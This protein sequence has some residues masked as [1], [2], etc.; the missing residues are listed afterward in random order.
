MTIVT[1][2][3]I[4]LFFLCF[5]SFLNS[6]A[7]RLVHPKHPRTKR[8]SCPHCHT[9]IAFYDLIPVV[10]W[11][12]LRARCRWCNKSISILYPLIELITAVVFVCL[13]I[14][15]PWTLWLPYGLFFTALIISIRTDLET[16]LLSRMVTIWFI[17]LGLFFSAVKLL[18]IT[19]S[20]SL[21]GAI[22][23]YALLWSVSRT[24]YIFTGKQGMGEGDMELLAMIG[25]FLGFNGM[26]LSLL[27][28]S[29]CG[30]L[31]GMLYLMSRG[32]KI[33]G[34]AIPFGPFLALGAIIDTFIE[35]YIS[36]L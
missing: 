4:G 16:M 5:G 22:A 20:Q 23:G 15:K 18:P 17:P 13:L 6:I 24:F 28:G 9:V 7:Y 33:L 35:P 30:S 8:S 1:V 21:V 26:W 32:T 34:I 11:L 27:I 19:F 31:L 36:S 14:F 2:F 29:C 10:S 3:L 25:S 12:I